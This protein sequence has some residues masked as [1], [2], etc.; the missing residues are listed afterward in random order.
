MKNAFHYTGFSEADELKR[1]YSSWIGKKAHIG[2]GQMETL[3]SIIIK[4]SRSTTISGKN[5]RHYTVYFEFE[6]K[7]R[8]SAATFLAVNSLT[9]VLN[10]SSVESEA[11]QVG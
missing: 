5:E 6:N 2:D 10:L 7:K 11:P 3:K 1:T 4:G 8:L 9:S